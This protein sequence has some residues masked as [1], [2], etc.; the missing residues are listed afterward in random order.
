MR[1]Q[2]Y[3]LCALRNSSPVELFKGQKKRSVRVVRSPS[4]PLYSSESSCNKTPCCSSFIGCR[5]QVCPVEEDE[6]ID[7]ENGAISRMLADNSWRLSL[8]CWLPL[9]YWFINL[10][11]SGPRTGLSTKKI[12]RVKE[13]CCYQKRTIWRRGAG[14]SSSVDSVS[15]KDTNGMERRQGAVI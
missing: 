4:P 13:W 3:S 5:C 10:V 14:R 12:Y 6:R 9:V 7:I 8:S 1:T 2:H 15:I 11:R